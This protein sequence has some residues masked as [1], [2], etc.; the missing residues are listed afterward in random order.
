LDTNQIEATLDSR[1]FYYVIN[2][3]GDE[4]KPN[5]CSKVVIDYTGKFTSGQQFDG[6][7]N[8]TFYL[9]TV[10]P[11]FRMGVPLIGNGGEITLFLPPSLG[12]GADDNGAIPGGSILVFRIKLHSFTQK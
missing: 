4:Q 12:Y 6:N 5:Q 2:T 7:L 1:G 11:G 10:V 3:P 9:S 8:S